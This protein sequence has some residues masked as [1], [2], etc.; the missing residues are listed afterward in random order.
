MSSGTGYNVQSIQ[1]TTP[2]YSNLSTPGSLPIVARTES[3]VKP[4]EVDT[5]MMAI[6]ESNV[7]FVYH[8]M[9][10]VDDLMFYSIF[11]PYGVVNS[12]NIFRDPNTQISL[13]T[14]LPSL[15]NHL[16]IHFITLAVLF[17]TSCRFWLYR[18]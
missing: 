3:Q 5:P 1:H 17:L 2:L 4:R 16:L 12:C 13:G 7:L 10:D 8:L 6:K 18:V 15:D 11:A 9:T 14:L